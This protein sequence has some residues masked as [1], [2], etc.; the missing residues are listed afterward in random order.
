MKKP[1]RK[2]AKPRLKKPG[3]ARS[4]NMRAI[5]SSNTGPERAVRALLSG[6]GRRYRL[7][8]RDL[9]GSPDIAFIGRRCAVF[10]HGCFWHGHKCAR[11]GRVPKTNRAYWVQKIT[12]NRE[13]DAQARRRLRALG[14]RS[15]IIWEC[16]L[17]NEARLSERLREFLGPV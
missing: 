17:K 14:W 16:Q 13:R 12:R 15:L 1:A 3:E 6:M 2:P 10:V 11:G 9:P 8:R 5:K 7:Q 4:A